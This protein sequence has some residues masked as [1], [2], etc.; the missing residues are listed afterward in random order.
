[1][2]EQLSLDLAG[3]DALER[4]DIFHHGRYVTYGDVSRHMR[5][6]RLAG[7][8]DE[9]RQLIDVAAERFSC[10]GWRKQ[11]EGL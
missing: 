6:L 11:L 2:T 5:K 3:P 1:M 4:F 8:I 10:P 9:L 7:R